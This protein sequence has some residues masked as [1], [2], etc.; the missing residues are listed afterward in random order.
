[1]RQDKKRASRNKKIKSDI[2][3]LVRKIREAIKKNDHPKA[4]EWL[5]QAI[6]KIDRA[7]QK[8]VIKKNTAGRK[9][10]RLFKA[11]NSLAKKK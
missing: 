8:G 7:A 6:K 4:D 9:K 11:V 5:K 10:S 2:T 3:A 1:M